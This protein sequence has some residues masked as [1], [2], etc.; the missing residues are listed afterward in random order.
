MNNR[1]IM[2]KLQGNRGYWGWDTVDNWGWGS[3][4]WG[5]RGSISCIKW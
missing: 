1:G 4:N 2:Y 3:D 5:N